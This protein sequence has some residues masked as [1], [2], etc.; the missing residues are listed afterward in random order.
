MKTRIVT[1]GWAVL[2]VIAV[3][4]GGATGQRR[5]VAAFYPIAYAAQQIGGPT[6]SV[7]NLTPA[8]AE[9]HDLEL[10][11]SDVVAI[12]RADDVFYLG[13][14]FQPAV[15]KAV[16]STHAHGID[17]LERVRLR[18]G[19][20]E[21]GHPGLDPHVWLDPVRYA[22]IART[23][24]HVLA[25]PR[26]T[27]S[28]VARLRA[29]DGVYRAGPVTG[30]R[31]VAQGAREA[32]RHGAPLARDDRLLRNL[33]QRRSSPRPSR[34]TLMSRPPCSTRSRV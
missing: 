16:A 14:G 30:G 22:G 1:I 18:T 23:I 7:R 10:Q 13:E 21:Q 2:M 29:L 17:L 20:D 27:A 5:V 12:Q 6:V 31:A 11:P 9:P 34:G 4:A 33:G 19:K 28:F 24:G 26:A 15:A 8:G 32:D 25:R 3:A